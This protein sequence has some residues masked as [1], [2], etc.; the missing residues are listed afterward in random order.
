MDL[1]VDKHR[2][3]PIETEAK[4]RSSRAFVGA[5]DSPAAPCGC[6]RLRIAVLPFAAGRSERSESLAFALGQ[7][8][9]A[10]LGRFRHF[11]VIAG[12]SPDSAAP[13]CLVR[14]HEFRR[15]ELDYLVDL[16]VS[17]NEQGAEI[18]VS[19]LDL[20]GDA[21]PIWSKRLDPTTCGTHRIDEFVATHVAGCIGPVIP[22][23]EAD[24]R[25][26]NRYGATGFLRRA[27]P[28]MFSMDREKFRQA[29]QLIKSA[30]EV[31]SDDAEIAAWAAR[32]QHLNVTLGY[33]PHSR[34]EVAK[35]GNFAL[36]AVKSNPDH[37]EAVGI[38]AHYR[39]F[40]EKKFDTALDDFDRSLGINP[41]LAF[42]WGLS[43]LTFCY[44]GE[45]RAALERL[46]RYS[47]LAPFDPHVS[48]FELIY[49][50]AY[51]FNQD[52]ER[53][54]IVS[55]R[56]VEALPDFVNGYKP[57]VAAL[58][59]LDRREEAK[60]YVDKLLKLEPGFT[61]EEFG[62]VYPIKKPRDRKRYMEGLR[63][64]GVPIG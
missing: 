38:Y 52:Y 41:S 31:D 23:M 10:A 61:V 62:E 51:L 40:T 29:G 36:R 3:R 53:A 47:E 7:E 20:R 22:L 5:P 11:D 56:A 43:A 8:V 12:T 54:A 25:R 19:L 33:A 16:T 6:G 60:P 57:L 37:A 39:S 42:I 48:S 50:I 14:E 30:L 2:N 46:D 55:R 21:R 59:H 18:N 28:L 1:L 26:R 44:I 9:T 13:T 32:W 64:A 24:A 49:A 27:V 17:E 58:G 45:P 63:L 15:M 35:V 4:R 34:H